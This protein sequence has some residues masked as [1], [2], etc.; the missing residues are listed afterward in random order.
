L[1]IGKTFRSA[2]QYLHYQENFT[3]RYPGSRTSST[4]IVGLTTTAALLIEILAAAAE[5][6]HPR[7][8]NWHLICIQFA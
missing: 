7:Q 4:T 1:T 8:V 3:A 2:K 5:A 6:P